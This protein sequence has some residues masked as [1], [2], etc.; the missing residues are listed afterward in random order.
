MIDSVKNWL[1]AD[2]NLPFGYQTDRWIA[3]TGAAVF[4]GLLYWFGGLTAIAGAAV[5]FLAGFGLAG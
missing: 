2:F 5:A 1:T 3:I 4:I